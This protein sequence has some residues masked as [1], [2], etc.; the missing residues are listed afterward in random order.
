M[1]KENQSEDWQ[2]S[3]T[4]TLRLSQC[5]PQIG[6]GSVEALPGRDVPGNS[7]LHCHL[8]P[9]QSQTDEPCSGERCGPKYVLEQALILTKVALGTECRGQGPLL[10]CTMCGSNLSPPFD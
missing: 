7:A 3:A 8:P 1:C 2:P 5:D 6:V 10:H 4:L 9:C